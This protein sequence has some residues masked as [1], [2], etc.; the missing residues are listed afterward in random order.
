MAINNLDTS[1]KDCC[2]ATW[3][4]GEDSVTQIGCDRGAIEQYKK[5]GSSV[6]ECYDEE[7]EFFVI[8]QRICPYYRTQ[9]WKNRFSADEIES[10][11]ELENRLHFHVVIFANE[12]IDDLQK[13]ID[14]I[15]GQELKPVKTT[16]I[17]EYEHLLRVEDVKD[18]TS[19]LKINWT[20]NSQKLEMSRD[21]AVYNA[22][23]NS[24]C[25]YVVI[26]N[27]GHEVPNDFLR[28]V[29]DYIMKC[30]GQFAVI[31]PEDDNCMV[32]SSSVYRYWYINGNLDNKRT[33]LENILEWGSEE[34]QK[35]KDVLL[36]MSKIRNLVS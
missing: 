18:I 24:K 12:N 15:A 3:G 26:V 29:N 13:T 23:K 22:N 28:I 33:I 32:A 10:R 31:L 21:S 7:R 34:C 27:A 36:T 16:I 6:H 20:I 19:N 1:C 25:Q 2:F 4:D 9:K 11:I 14:S 17:L 30:F 35:K 8:F 5:I